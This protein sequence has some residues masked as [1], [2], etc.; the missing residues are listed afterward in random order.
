MLVDFLNG[1]EAL[2]GVHGRF[3]P[4]H[5]APAH[6][7]LP[8]YRRRPRPV[9]A[10]V[11]RLDH[12][13][14]ESAATAGVVCQPE[15]WRVRGRMFDEREQPRRHEPSRAHRRSA[16]RRTVTSTTPGRG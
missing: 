2:E 6:P 14:R 15:I 7:P 10:A 13:D 4:V 11:L 1:A 5:R 16:A 3:A 12:P 8:R 9:A